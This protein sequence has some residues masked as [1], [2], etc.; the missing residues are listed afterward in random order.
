MRVVLVITKGEIGGAQT[1]VA[2]LC[3]A[4]RDR[5]E[6]LVLIG[7]SESSFL[8]DALIASNVRVE[9]IE[10]LSN[11]VSPRSLVACVR[12]VAE[13]ARSWRADVIHVHSAVA[14][15]VG[16]IAG[17]L[18]S[19]PV[20]YTVHGFAFKQEVDAPRRLCAF[21]AERLLAPL[22][23]HTIC[24][25]P[26][27]LALARRLRLPDGRVSVISNG[28]SDSPLRADPS[29]VPTTIIMVARMAVQKRHDLLLEALRVLRAR[30][31]DPPRTLLA[32]DGPLMPALRQ[33]ATASGLSCVN[34]CGNISDISTTLAQ[35]QLFVLLS[36]HEGQPISIIEAMRAGLPIVASDIPGVRAQVTDGVEGLLAGPTAADVADVLG[37][38]IGDPALRARMGAAARRRYETEFSAIGMGERVARVYAETIGKRTGEPVSIAQGSS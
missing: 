10:R 27:E 32:G 19:I 20:V 23:A 24:V 26:A 1:H 2:E 16:R 34:F 35:C 37:R 7:G 4:L 18:S 36:N 13:Y 5:C 6:F 29:R 11:N 12:Q 38:L 15:V 9:S 21:A 22:N 17:R 14:S 28:I 31:I 3:G 25:S 8:R 33:A 30:G